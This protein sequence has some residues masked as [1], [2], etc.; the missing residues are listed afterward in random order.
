MIVCSLDHI[1]RGTIIR[2]CQS[3]HEAGVVVY[4]GETEPA[5]DSTLELQRAILRF[6]PHDEE[7]VDISCLLA[8]SVRTDLPPEII[9]LYKPISRRRAWLNDYGWRR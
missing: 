2:V 1:D 6:Y 8:L 5:L 4:G 7:V 9:P 3:L